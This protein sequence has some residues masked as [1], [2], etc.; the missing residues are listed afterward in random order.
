[1]NNQNRY[2][3]QPLRLYDLMNAFAV[4]C[5]NCDDKAEVSVP[6]NFDFVNATLK[7]TSCHYSEKAIELTRH[8]PS[9]KA[10]CHHC[11]EFLDLTS[12]DGF[13]SIP[14]YVNLKC[15]ACQTIN[16]VSEHW[17]SYIAK[18]ND[19]GI[20]DPAFGL[21]LWYQGFVK[22][23][24]IWA[25]NLEHLKEI[26]NYVR[27]TLRERTTDKFK[28]TM[29]EKLPDFIKTAKNRDEVIRALQ[30]ME[31]TTLKTKQ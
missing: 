17:Q 18:Y 31:K 22:G 24:I 28:M 21:P 1:M 27:A 16:K 19:T 26:E 11:L 5:P 23:N 25:F 10:K 8:K 9:G 6:N 7:C 15:H 12:I 30:K 14:A 4:H 20:I 13:K 2:N 3:G 29:V